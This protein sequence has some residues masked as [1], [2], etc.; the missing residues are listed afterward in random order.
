MA[1]RE[2]SA[3]LEKSGQA[4]YGMSFLTKLISVYPGVINSET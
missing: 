2:A 3:A 4:E 1:E